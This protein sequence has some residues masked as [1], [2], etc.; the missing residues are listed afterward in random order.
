[1]CYCDLHECCAG[2]RNSVG[3][4]KVTS[5]KERDMVELLP[6]LQPYP[7]P[8]PSALCKCGRSPMALAETKDHA[9]FCV[10]CRLRDTQSLGAGMG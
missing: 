10:A 3:Y 8:K 9:Y 6:A 4:K 5:G 7:Q 1:M 2:D